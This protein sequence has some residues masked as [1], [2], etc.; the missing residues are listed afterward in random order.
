MERRADTER[1][2]H[3]LAFNRSF[4]EKGLD[5]WNWD[6]SKMS[7]SA[8]SCIAIEDSQHGLQA[9]TALGIKTVITVNDYTQSEDFSEAILVLNHLGEQSLPFSAI[10]GNVGAADYLNLD[11]LRQLHNK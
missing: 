2:G 11:L 3:R 6:A 4:N 8:D 7:L 10:S 9:A 5:D 1:D